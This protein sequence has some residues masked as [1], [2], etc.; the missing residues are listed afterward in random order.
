MPHSRRPMVGITTDLAEHANGVRVFTYRG[1]VEAVERGGGLPVLL[2]PVKGVG[3]GAY[4][5]RLDAFVLTGG[6]DP[7]TEPFG[8]PTHG[9]AVRVHADRQAFETALL[10][11]L[12]RSRPDAP[13]LGVCLGMQLMA[14]VAGGRLEQYM[15]ETCATHEAHWEREHAVEPVG[16]AGL[17]MRGLVRSKHKQAVADAGGMSVIARAPDGVVEAICDGQRRF[18]VGVQWHPERTADDA[19]GAAVFRGLV[20]A[21]SGVGEERRTGCPRPRS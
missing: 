20:L 2:P 8:E 5:D 11:E 14:L 13:V 15:P 7:R 6:D 10:E 1:Y 9:K 21:G 18:Y 17:V 16:D 3:V 19:V 12:A 4:V